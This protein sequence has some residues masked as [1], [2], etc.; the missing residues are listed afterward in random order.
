[1]KHKRLVNLLWLHC[2]SLGCRGMS[3]DTPCPLHV[4]QVNLEKGMLCC[5]YMPQFREE[6]EQSAWE[7]RSRHLCALVTLCNQNLVVTALCYKHT[8]AGS[9]YHISCCGL[10]AAHRSEHVGRDVG[11]PALLSQSRGPA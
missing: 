5:V 2:C 6:C 8:A 1:M 7:K 11:S 3:L 10:G 4:K 9:S